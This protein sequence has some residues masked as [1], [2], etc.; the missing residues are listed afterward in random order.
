MR[1]LRMTVVVFLVAVVGLPVTVMAQY[2]WVG[3]W[4]DPSATTCGITDQSAG[5]K[6]IYVVVS[7]SSGITATQFSAPKPSCFPATFLSDTQVFPVTL[8]NSQTGVSI[9][10]G[11]CKTSRVH[12]LTMNYFTTGT[13]EGC[14]PYRVLPHPSVESGEVE[15]ADCDFNV[16]FGQGR[17]TAVLEAP[18]LP[19]LIESRVPSDE[20]IEQPLNTSMSWTVF[21]CDCLMCC[22]YSRVYFGT[23]PDPP[24]VTD[25]GWED[26]GQCQYE[27]GPLMPNTTYYWKIETS[28]VRTTTPVWSFSTVTGVAAKPTTWGRV[29]SLYGE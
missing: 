27:P 11:A 4:E 1:I 20:A 2:A 21:R 16:F 28:P 22:S 18:N 23:T 29:K 9:G 14:C 24:L 13:T 7:E 6:P 5:W 17:A 3:L 26:L 19:P 15:F 12:C 10:F 25:W 8:G